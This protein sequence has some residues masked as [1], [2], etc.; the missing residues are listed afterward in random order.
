MNI[1][2]EG[3]F[4]FVYPAE[5][6]LVPK[7]FSREAARARARE[8]LETDRALAASQVLRYFGV[9]PQELGVPHTPVQVFEPVHMRALRV[10]TVF[11]TATPELAHRAA[12][13]LAHLAGAAE[14]RLRLG[15]P[16]HEWSSGDNTDRHLPDAVFTRD[17]RRYAVEYD[18]GS[19]TRRR[20]VEKI[21][22]FH[23]EYDAV[24]WAVP[25][26]RERGHGVQRNNRAASLRKMIS[27]S[28]ELR[29]AELPVLILAVNWWQGLTVLD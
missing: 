4:G 19:Y 5:L 18:R 2:K 21:L 8:A 28:P 12:P 13:V 26:G 16:P 9:T 6:P 20:I 24:I 15:I 1:G 10:Q 23:G 14:V 27:L 29:Q 22:T 25:E 7:A 11:C 17:G 3:V